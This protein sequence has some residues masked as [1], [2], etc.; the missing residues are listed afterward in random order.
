MKTWLAEQWEPSE[1]KGHDSYDAL[2]KIMSAYLWFNSFIISVS[3]FD[4]LANFSALSERFLNTATAQLKPRALYMFTLKL[5]KETCVK[6]RWIRNTDLNFS[7]S[8]AFTPMSAFQ[9]V[10][11]VLLKQ[12]GNCFTVRAAWGE[13]WQTVKLIRCG[14]ESYRIYLT[15][16][17]HWIHLHPQ[18]FYSCHNSS[19]SSVA[20]S[21]NHFSR[22]TC[23]LILAE[24]KFT[25]LVLLPQRNIE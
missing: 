23:L 6:T 11:R 3:I 25:P 18:V 24:Y 20:T 22:V 8:A 19:S 16:S 12:T 7:V 13:K 21:H 5:S 1:V 4:I 14:F 15:V 2:T 9:H 10:W 17:I